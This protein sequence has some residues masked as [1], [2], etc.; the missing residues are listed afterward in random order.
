M[1]IILMAGSTEHILVTPENREKLNQLGNTG[2]TYNNVITKL[3][4]NYE[5]MNKVV[6][7]DLIKNYKDGFA[8]EG[9]PTPKKIVSNTH[10]KGRVSIQS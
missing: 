5:M 10:D 9:Q 1:L 3:L 4:Q 7:V 8:L 2:D 6:L